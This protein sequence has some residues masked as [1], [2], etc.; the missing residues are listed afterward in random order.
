MGAPAHSRVDGG[1]GGLNNWHGTYLPLRGLS[2][3]M[4]NF[5]M[6]PKGW[7]TPLEQ[8]SAESLLEGHR[9][10]DYDEAME[11]VLQGI[12]DGRLRLSRFTTVRL[13]RKLAYR[14]RK[15]KKPSKAMHHMTRKKRNREQYKGIDG[16]KR[17]GKQSLHRASRHGGFVRA[18]IE[19][20]RNGVE[21]MLTE[22]EWNSLWDSAP[23]LGGVEAYELRAA[24]LTRLMRKDVRKPFSYANCAIFW[25]KMGG[26]LVQLTH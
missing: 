4:D 25:G 20:R 7:G 24:G 13:K 5:Q 6:G 10:I 21:W 12:A 19:A 26:D 3:P 2:G 1:K 16:K 15:R 17:R 9:P 8:R 11:V 18:R 22:A 14:W 23:P